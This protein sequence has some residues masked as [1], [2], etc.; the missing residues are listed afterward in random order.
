MP[1]SG[2]RWTHELRKLVFARITMQFGPYHTWGARWFPSGHQVAYRQVLREI[3]AYLRTQTRSQVT[4]DAVDQQVRFGCTPQSQLAGMAL[5]RS[6]L[7]NKA[8][9][10][11][12]G[13]LRH[14]DLPGRIRTR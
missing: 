12:S 6:L 2:M 11:E 3:A 4:A 14:R 1:A 10:L 9:A 7:L 13:F 5:A 8:A